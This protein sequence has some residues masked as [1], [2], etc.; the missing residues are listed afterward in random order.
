L[1]SFQ[2]ASEKTK[3]ASGGEETASERERLSL[4]GK[5]PHPEETRTDSGRETASGGDELA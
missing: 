5:S 3:T 2:D 4:E 1:A